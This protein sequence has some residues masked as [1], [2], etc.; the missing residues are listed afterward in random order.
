MAVL[1]YCAILAALKIAK[2]SIGVNSE[3]VESLK[4]EALRVFYSDFDD[5]A[6]AP[7]VFR[8][9]ALEFHRVIASIFRQAAVVP[10]RFPNLLKSREELEAHLRTNSQKYQ[11]F[12]EKT[13][14]AVQIEIAP[15]SATSPVKA[16][17][18]KSGTEYLREK[19]Q[20]SRAVTE[21]SELVLGEC[22]ELVL[23]S[24]TSDSRLY[25]LVGRGRVDDL[26]ERL[27]D[28]KDIRISGPW[29]AAEFL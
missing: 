17:R 22:K 9:S 26:R 1:P 2:P 19:Q 10:F 4:I 12:L 6:L 14:D 11:S 27:K 16:E 8:Q 5:S 3:R 20:R 15:S 18:E 24:K 29:P 13:Q 23:E 25:L 28:L 21:L 7:E